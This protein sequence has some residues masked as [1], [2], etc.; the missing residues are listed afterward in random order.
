MNDALLV[1]AKRM[2][3]RQEV[4]SCYA[5]TFD[6]R[7][8]FHVIEQKGRQ[9]RNVMEQGGG[10]YLFHLKE[11]KL[12]PVTEFGDCAITE[13]PEEMEQEV[14]QKLPR[15]DL[16]AQVQIKKLMKKIGFF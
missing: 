6:R 15:Y 11:D 14:Y 10:I 13:L 12:I 1:F 2:N 5:L 8:G 3:E 4:R 9:L 16:T 7:R